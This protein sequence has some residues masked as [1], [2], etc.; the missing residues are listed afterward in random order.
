MLAGAQALVSVLVAVS[1]SVLVPSAW[2]AARRATRAAAT[3]PEAPASQG[4]PPVGC[5][6][7]VGD[8]ELLGVLG[9]HILVGTDASGAD[10]SGAAWAC[11]LRGKLRGKRPRVG[12]F[13]RGKG[14]G[15]GATAGRAPKALRLRCRL[16]GK[17]RGKRLRV[18]RLR[19]E[20]L[21]VVP[22]GRGQGAA[23]D[24]IAA[25]AAVRLWCLSLWCR[26]AVLV[27]WLPR[28]GAARQG[29]G[30]AVVDVP[31]DPRLHKGD[32]SAHPH[33]PAA[34]WFP[35][36]EVHNDGHSHVDVLVARLRK[37]T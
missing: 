6:L 31:L 7:V 9:G 8:G 17:L 32:L 30:A 33:P 3:P 25:A 10:A 11:W 26:E 12:P 16:R 35:A 18:K 29:R 1:V 20:R 14:R 2:R 21:C 28:L 27:L 36:Q 34:K 19:V 5:F 24:D 37:A 22:G 13:S 15:K 4:G 23:A